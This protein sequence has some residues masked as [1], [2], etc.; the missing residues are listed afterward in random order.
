MR[1]EWERITSTAYLTLLE[2]N[3]NEFPVD[4][5]RIK[6]KG[7]VISSYQHYAKKTGLTVEQI[8]LEHELDDAFFLGELRPGLKLILYNKEKYGARLKHT[9]WHEVGHVKLNHNAHTDREEIE[10]HF[11]ASQ[12]NAPNIIIKAISNRGYKINTSL[13][14][15]T[16]ELSKESANRKLEYLKKYSFEHENEHDDTMLIQFSDFL[17]KNFPPKLQNSY[18]EEE[19]RQ[20]ERDNW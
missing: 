14:M 20:F 3:F 10:A 16:F 12:A 9:L 13:L 17:N 1:Y 15:Q 2:L 7:V 18:D 8:S 6:N 11:F 4:P 19:E 5:K